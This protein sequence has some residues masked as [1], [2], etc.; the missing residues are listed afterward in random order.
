MK[1]ILVT[2][3]QGFIG[4]HLVE[5][6]RL[7]EE[8]FWVNGYDLKNAGDNK[9]HDFSQITIDDLIKYNIDT[10]FHLAALTDVQ[11]SIGNPEKY[12]KTNV[13]DTLKFMKVCANYRGIK[14]FVFTSSSAVYGSSN[15]NTIE[16][17][18]ICYP[19]SPY[20]ADKLAIENYLHAFFE[21]YG[22]SYM[23]LRLFNVY[24][25]YS[26]TKGIIPKIVDCIENDKVLNLNNKGDSIR[27]FIYVDDVVQSLI[28]AA[29]SSK[30]SNF[31]VN[32][33]TGQ[34]ISIIDLEKL[35][36]NIL[37][38]QPAIIRFNKEKVNE[39]QSSVANTALAKTID[40]HCY[41]T[42]LEDGL[43]AYLSQR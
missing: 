13:S 1:N 38:K 14:K 5:R 25:P 23:A 29:Q 12:F 34:G 24:G 2:G 9:F 17:S 18:S 35:I 19:L 21:S 10:V 26:T 20:A 41:E 40:V 42:K 30:R 15:S 31:A 7:K 37:Q 11:E 22:L 32:V 8:G 39:P 27:D 33:G 28:L 3:S 6:L 36:E 4:S 43:R 16:S